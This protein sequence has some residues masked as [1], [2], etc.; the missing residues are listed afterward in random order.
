MSSPQDLL[1]A[2]FPKIH[3]AALLRHFSGMTKDYQKSEWE[4]CIAKSGKFIEASLKALYVRT[5]GT[6]AKGKAFKVD[7]VINALAQTPHG[8][9]HDTIRLTIPRACRFVYD[10]ASSKGRHDSDEVDPNEMDA[11]AVVTQCSWILAEM[12]RHAQH[13]ATVMQDAKEA[14]ESLMRRKYPLIEQIDRQTYFHGT[15]ASATDMALVILFSRYPARVPFD[16][17]IEQLQGN[18]FSLK[19]SRTAVSRINRYV[20]HDNS[21][22]LTLLAPGLLKAEEI[23]RAASGN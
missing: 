11:N 22:R 6:P 2:V 4:D 7:T 8:M 18:K 13:G 21:G 3:V 16:D 15:K 12:I 19:N 10:V 20:H 17:L 1:I 5:G 9:V 14:V 23:M